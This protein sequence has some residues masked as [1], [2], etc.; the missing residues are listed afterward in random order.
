MR[1]VVTGFGL[2]GGHARNPSLDVGRALVDRLRVAGLEASFS[3]LPVT[4]EAARTWPRPEPGTTWVIHLGLA[5]SRSGVDV[6]L[7]AWNRIGPHA[8]GVGDRASDGRLDDMDVTR[9]ATPL[10]VA[11]LA[12]ALGSI[13]LPSGRVCAVACSDDPG[14]YICNATYWYSLAA[15]SRGDAAP[16]CFVHV[17][18][19]DEVEAAAVGSALADALRVMSDRATG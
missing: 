16:A 3:E 13:A 10:P 18:P 15:W 19:L 12:R 7:V 17:P 5:A 2:F 14:D 8:D 6:E 11:S 1:F 4:L 9:I